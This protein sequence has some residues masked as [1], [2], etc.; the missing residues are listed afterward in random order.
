VNVSGK[1]RADVFLMNGQERAQLARDG[2]VV[3]EHVFSSQ[4]TAQ[5]AADCEQL[6]AE[7]V[8]MKRAARPKVGGYVFEYRDELETTVKWERDVPDQPRGVEP[9][10]HL[11]PAL[12][13]WG[14]D[15]RLLDPCKEV[16]GAEEVALFTEKLNM[17]R[18]GTG[19]YVQL[20][21]DFP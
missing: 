5:M 15:P 4:E 18:A 6:M 14:Q 21:Q 9:F 13:A 20:H 8:A 7:L 17:K 11:S 16:C 12:E 2:Y 3:R 1:D 10:A 19:G